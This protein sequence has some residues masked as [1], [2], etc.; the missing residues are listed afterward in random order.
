MSL[1][2]AIWYPLG[3][4]VHGTT[5]TGQPVTLAVSRT[6]DGRIC[7]NL[8]GDRYEFDRDAALT[9]AAIHSRALGV[10]RSRPDD[11]PQRQPEATADDF[12]WLNNSRNHRQVT[13]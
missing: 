1:T 10:D 11:L 5:D 12:E 8:S 6:D 3:G 2:A 13:R 4:P 7:L 9:L